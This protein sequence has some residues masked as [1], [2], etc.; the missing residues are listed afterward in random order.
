METLTDLEK[1]IEILM[2]FLMQHHFVFNK[3][4]SSIFTDGYLTQVKFT[5]KNKEFIIGYRSSVGYL[6]YKIDNFKV[7]HDFY[8][9]KLGFAEKRMFK[10]TQTENRLVVFENILHD[11]EFLTED[12]FDGACTQLKEFSS[13]PDN[14][15]KLYDKRAEMARERINLQ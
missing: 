6:V 10:A 3:F 11:F 15:I 5:N 13:L 14:I 12:F 2:P 8:L 7:S 9:D 1:G 4:E